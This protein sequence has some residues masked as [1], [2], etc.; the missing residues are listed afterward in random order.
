MLIPTP[1][2]WV[3]VP[4]VVCVMCM[5]SQFLF[6]CVRAHIHFCVY[7]F[8]Q[9]RRGS[10]LRAAIRSD[11]N[12]Y[13]L[14]CEAVFDVMVSGC[15]LSGRDVSFQATDFGSYCVSSAEDWLT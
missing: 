8:A 5:A 9:G 3:F 4:L 2:V 12:S 6:A 1:V 10:A 15:H 14:S 13:S 7:S 11:F